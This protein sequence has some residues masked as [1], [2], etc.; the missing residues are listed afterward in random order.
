MKRI[1]LTTAILS[2][3]ALSACNSTD[4]IYSQG[5]WGPRHV[6]RSYPD[7]PAPWGLRSVEPAPDGGAGPVDPAYV[8][9]DRALDQARARA[10]AVR[11]EPDMG[12]SPFP[13]AAEP[14]PAPEQGGAPVA[15]PAQPPLPAPESGAPANASPPGVFTSPRRA[16]SYSG[17]WKAAVGSS[18]C[19]IQLSSVPSLDLYKA[20]TQGCS[21]EG[22]RSVNGWSF[23][24]DQVLLFSRGKVIAR[25]TG[26]E[27]AL[28]GKLS[29]SDIDVTMT[30]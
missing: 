17:T 12:P 30:R 13:H 15:A 7:Y 6:K 25:L 22:M 3:A 18:S 24:D 28:N 1:F 5:P 2:T 21:H 16:S 20:S 9:E 8:A 23:R 26:A 10:Y 14:M 19:R 4:M 29:G 11:L 27:A